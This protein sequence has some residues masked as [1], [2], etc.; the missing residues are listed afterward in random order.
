MKAAVANV[1]VESGAARRLLPATLHTPE[2]SKKGRRGFLPFFV[3]LCPF[4]PWPRE[5]AHRIVE[6]PAPCRLGREDRIENH[7]IRFV[8]ELQ[9]PQFCL[10][11][12]QAR[13]PLPRIL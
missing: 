6:S 7:L 9:R 11:E 10:P 5:A 12:C 13:R 2:P 1:A 4:R 8:R 3:T